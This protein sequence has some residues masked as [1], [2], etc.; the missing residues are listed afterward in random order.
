MGPDHHMSPSPKETIPGCV[1]AWSRRAN[2][3]KAFFFFLLDLHTP[4]NIIKIK[5]DQNK[6]TLNKKIKDQGESHVIN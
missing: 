2:G 5:K 3:D 4:H 6:T 1:C